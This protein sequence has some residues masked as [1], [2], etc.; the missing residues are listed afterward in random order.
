MTAR[1]GWGGNPQPIWKVW[2]DFGIQD[3]R[4]I[5][6]WDPACP[7]KTDRKDVLATTYVKQGKTLVAVASW[8][9][10]AVKC[11]LNVDW[12]SLGLDPAKAKISAAEVKDFQS[13][14]EF[15]P[16]DEVPVAPGRGWL[17]VI[18]E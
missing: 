16:G 8:A 2:D 15:R 13:S 12:K 5:G 4:M 9:P 3:A 18:H 17:L 14:A 10:T 7:V 1:L 11:K 6:Y